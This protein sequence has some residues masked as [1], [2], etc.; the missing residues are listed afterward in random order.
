[1]KS[2][3]VHAKKIRSRLF[4]VNEENGWLFIWM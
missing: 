1:M 3:S 2:V 4:L